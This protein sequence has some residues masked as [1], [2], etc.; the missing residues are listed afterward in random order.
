MDDQQQTTYDVPT[1][2]DLG[3]LA[4]LTQATGFS[5]AED[6]GA[7]LAIHHEATPSGPVGP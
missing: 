7:K 5:G 6:G 1:V 3:T 2:E 4:D